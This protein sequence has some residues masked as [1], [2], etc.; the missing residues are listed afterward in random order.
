MGG[1]VR[2]WLILAA[3]V[4]A[5]FLAGHALWQPDTAPPPATV[6]QVA[7]ASTVPATELQD[8][9][10]EDR[11]SLRDWSDGALI[12]NFWATWCAPCRREMPLLE[13]VHQQWQGRR[14][15][16]VGVAIDREEPVRTF[17]A[18]SGISYPILL[19]E[20]DAMD[21]AESLA[22]G[23]PG[24]PLTVVAAPGGEILARHVGELH[25]AD[26]ERL[27]ATLAALLDGSIAQP[28]ARRRLEAAANDGGR[29]SPGS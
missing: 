4:L 17:I 21:L 24:L 23:F 29:A 9:A 27:V 26:L 11:R 8:L 19:G 1:R 3:C 20:R 25:P 28:E 14:L 6:A 22:P 15:A 18:E 12:I 13:Q 10:G 16:V 2:L 5:G 7:A